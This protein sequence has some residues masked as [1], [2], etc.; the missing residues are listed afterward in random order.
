MGLPANLRLGLSISGE[1]SHKQ[2]QRQ[3]T[4]DMSGLSASKV[5][6]ARKKQ[7]VVEHTVMSLLERWLLE[8]WLLLQAFVQLASL[9]ISRSS[10]TAGAELAGVGGNYA[11]VSFH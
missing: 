10:V 1:M 6:H 2:R 9:A 11:R 8:R 3:L 4:F 7:G 5:E